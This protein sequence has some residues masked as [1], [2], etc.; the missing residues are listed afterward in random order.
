[1]RYYS[2]Y[3]KKFYDSIEDC[4]AAEAEH[5]EKE[6]ARKSAEEN[7]LT[8]LTAQKHVVDELRTQYNE[9]GKQYN[10]EYSRL[11]KM[12]NTFSRKYGYV[13]K[14]FNSLDLFLSLM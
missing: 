8:E 1:M 4:E 7:L 3:T 6:N 2:D 9:V 10:E 14:G 5:I 13:P 11:S 12:L